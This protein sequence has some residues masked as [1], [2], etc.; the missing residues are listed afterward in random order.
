MSS[1]G[2]YISSFFSRPS[3]VPVTEETKPRNDSEVRDSYNAKISTAYDEFRAQIAEFHNN[4]Q[5]F[6]EDLAKKAYETRNIIKEK[7]QEETSLL[8]RAFIAA[9]NLIKYGSLNVGYEHLTKTG[10]NPEEI[11]YSAFKTG[12]GDLGLQNNGFG[13]KLEVWNAIKDSTLLYPEDITPEMVAAY[14]AQ[15]KG[16]VDVDAILAARPGQ[17]PNPTLNPFADLPK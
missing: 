17:S 13:D 8:G 5:C 15:P 2:S 11:A 14:K 16:K 12:G 1:I 9:R 6:G 4:E 7:H 3:E 10:K